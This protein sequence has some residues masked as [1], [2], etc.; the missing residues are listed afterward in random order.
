ME[1]IVPTKQRTMTEKR[2]RIVPYLNT[3]PSA[4]GRLEQVAA[5]DWPHSPFQLK[6]HLLL[7]FLDQLSSP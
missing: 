2:E 4:K 7:L 5:V 1:E 6:V 3:A